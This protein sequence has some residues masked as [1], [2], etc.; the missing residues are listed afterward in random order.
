MSTQKP[1]PLIWLARSI[2]R[3]WVALGSGERS[4]ARLTL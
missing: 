4:I 1:Q 3:S 2:T